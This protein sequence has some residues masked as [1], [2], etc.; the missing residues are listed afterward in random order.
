MGKYNNN[1]SNYSKFNAPKQTSSSTS[2]I[3][4]KSGTYV[5]QNSV[6]KEKYVG[7]SSN[8]YERVKQH[9]S[10]RGANWTSNSPGVWKVVK[11]YAGNNNATENAITKGVMRNEGI[12]NVRGGSYCKEWYPRS[13][14]QAIKKAHGF[15]NNGNR[16]SGSNQ[17]YESKFQNDHDDSDDYS[18]SD[19]SDDYSSSDDSSSQD[20]D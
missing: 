9:N 1:Y 20:D 19:D 10:G 2:N 3:Q 8:I 15:T 11:T 12:A 14:F 4:H 18:S 7:R 16:N 5:L 6:T 17:R 13:E